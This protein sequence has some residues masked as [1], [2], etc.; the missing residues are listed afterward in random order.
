MEYFKNTF[1]N[2]GA[3]AR[4]FWECLCTNLRIELKFY[5]NIAEMLMEYQ[6]NISGIFFDCFKTLSLEYF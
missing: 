2:F 4:I 3:I 5:W 6:W 1:G